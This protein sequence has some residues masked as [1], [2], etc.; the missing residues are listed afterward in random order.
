MTRSKQIV[1]ANC[2]SSLLDVLAISELRESVFKKRNRKIKF[3]HQYG[4]YI[5]LASFPIMLDGTDMA[6]LL[7][8]VLTKYFLLFRVR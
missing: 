7:I 5:L 3:I 8:T 4:F 6:F 2:I 1:V